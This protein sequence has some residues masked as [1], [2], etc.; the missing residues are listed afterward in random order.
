M[1]LT[2]TR[3]Y[4]KNKSSINDFFH[5]RILNP[6]P[7]VT[8][9]KWKY[10]G[11][12]PNIMEMVVHNN[13]KDIDSTNALNMCNGSDQLTQLKWGKFAVSKWD[14]LTIVP[15]KSNIMSFVMYPYFE[16]DVDCLKEKGYLM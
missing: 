7:N 8:G 11:G 6:L 14:D 15:E 2:L 12:H 1:Q 10:I 4:N 3:Q 9:E 5:E 16:K 13:K